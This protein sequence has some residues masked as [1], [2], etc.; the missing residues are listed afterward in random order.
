MLGPYLLKVMQIRGL[1][2]F[3]YSIQFNKQCVVYRLI[4]Y[5][6]QFDQELIALYNAT[7][8]TIKGEII[9]IEYLLGLLPYALVITLAII[10]PAFVI[11]KQEI[12][13]EGPFGWSSLTFTKRFSTKHW[14]SKLYRFYSGQD[15]WATEYHLYSNLIWLFMYFLV[16]AYIPYYEKLSGY[17]NSKALI[18]TLAFS[19]L[20]FIALCTVEDFTWFLI[21]PYYGPERHTPEYVPWFTTY[22][23]GVPVGYL[24]GTLTTIVISGVSAYLLGKPDIFATWL[25]VVLFLIVIC[26]WVIKPLSKKIHRIPLKKYWWKNIRDVVIQRCPY[27]IEDKTP[28]TEVIAWVLDSRTLGNLIINCKATELKRALGEEDCD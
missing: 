1:F 9:M 16:F 11:A 17:S 14:F 27:P 4:L 28:N 15:K 19:V 26:F 2:L 7:N 21:H 25:M 22:A 24:Y 18:G 5:I 10:I 13:I 3:N 8:S 12:A 23:G 6:I 20:S